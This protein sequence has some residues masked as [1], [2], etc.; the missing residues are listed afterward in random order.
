[1]ERKRGTAPTIFILAFGWFA[2]WTFRTVL[3]PVYAVIGAELGV[4]SSAAL[5]LISSCYFFGYVAM[6]IPGGI[7]AD[8][9]G[10]WFVVI[11]GFA[12]FLIGSVFTA[13]AGSIGVL[14]AGS[15]MAGVGTGTFYANAYSLS[16]EKFSGKSKTISTAFV[17]SGC[18][19][20]MVTGYVLSTLIV[21]KLG[22]SWRTP[23]WVAAAVA[24]ASVLILMFGLERQTPRGLT[25]EKFDIREILSPPV[26]TTC[27][28]YFGT[29][30]GYY[31]IVTWLPQFLQSERGFAASIAGVIAAVVPI[32]SVPGSFFFGRM[33]DRVG[34]RRKILLPVLQIGSALLL[35]AACSIRSGPLTIVLFIIY[36][37][38]GKMAEDPMIVLNVSD[39]LK[40]DHMASGLAIYNTVGMSASILAPT[41][42]GMMTD[43]TGNMTSGFFLAVFFMVITAAIFWLGNRKA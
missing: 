38:I 19:V 12:L 34:N 24:L 27:I 7:L 9:F 2:V 26:L 39:R 16:A 6:Q 23:A 37:L 4:S 22:G 33:A 8:R 13:T 21:N 36:G 40:Q 18:A 17:N 20:G 30:Y 14:Y 29:N 15:A 32:A 5:G 3:S 43:V 10:R 11:P 31:M 35:F 1:M 41:V 25:R 42:T 28:F